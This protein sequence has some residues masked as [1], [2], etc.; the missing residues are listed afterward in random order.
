MPPQQPGSVDQPL[1]VLVVE[2]NDVNRT[3]ALRQLEKLGYQ[4]R[5]VT[6]GMEAL[7][8]VRGSRFGVVLMDC[9]M[10]EMDGF[11]TTRAIREMESGTGRRTPIIALTANVTDRD[12]EACLDAG[13]DDFVPKPV[14]IE[15]LRSALAQWLPPAVSELHLGNGSS[16]ERDPPTEAVNSA[17]LQ[18][19]RDDVG[20][21][22]V[23]RLIDIYLS[24][25]PARTRAI[26]NALDGGDPGGLRLAAHTLKS[27]SAVLGATALARLCGQVEAAAR[28]GRTDGL[29]GWVAQIEAGS[30]R[31]RAAL[32]SEPVRSET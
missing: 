16:P 26:R 17:A 19:L 23:S 29:A 3:L 12:R 31:V 18:A 7:E 30:E 20:D 21:D 8:A 25:L 1:T 32:S 9:L 6:N 10:P 15:S 14:M 4:A 22:T 28:E 13:M 11:Q 2:D 27:A 24:H 5:A